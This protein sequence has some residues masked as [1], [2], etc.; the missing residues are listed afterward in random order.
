MPGQGSGVETIRKAGLIGRELLP[1]LEFQLQTTAVET[2]APN[3]VCAWELLSEM[4]TRRKHGNW[5][6]AGL[7]LLSSSL[8]YPRLQISF[9][10][11]AFGHL[12]ASV[13]HSTASQCWS[14]LARSL[15]LSSSFYWTPSAHHHLQHATHVHILCLYFFNSPLNSLRFSLLIFYSFVW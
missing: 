7:S 14:K 10:P 12:P 1:K 15:Q 5:L 9:P 2:S 6:F 13:L 4:E 3:K 8:I 11:A